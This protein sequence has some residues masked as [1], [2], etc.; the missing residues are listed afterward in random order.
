MV[1]WDRSENTTP[2]GAGSGKN[3]AVNG[4]EIPSRTRM[5]GAGGLEIT[6]TTA[7]WFGIFS[8]LWDIPP[9]PW[10]HPFKLL[11]NCLEL[12]TSGTPYA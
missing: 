8:T 10:N 12:R 4:V 1:V 3:G 9:C 11:E 5:D 6:S 7:T 2:M